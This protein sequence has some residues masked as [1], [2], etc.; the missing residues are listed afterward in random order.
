MKFEAWRRPRD[1][2]VPTW[3]STTTSTAARAHRRDHLT[4]DLQ[5]NVCLERYTLT[6]A[7][8]L[9]ML[10]ESSVSLYQAAQ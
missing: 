2:R 6:L 4:Y 10:N 1:R 5:V 9:V 3:L 7:Q 8:S